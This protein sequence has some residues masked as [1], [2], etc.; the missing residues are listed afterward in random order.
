MSSDK[1]SSIDKL[2]KRVRPCNGYFTQ[3]KSFICFELTGTRNSDYRFVTVGERFFDKELL[4][5]RQVLFS[6]FLHQEVFFKCLIIALPSQKLAKTAL[7]ALTN[8]F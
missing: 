5:I 8:C 7:M 6:V 2:P 3:R 1:L 4:C